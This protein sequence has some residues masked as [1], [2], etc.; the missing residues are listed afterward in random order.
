MVNGDMEEIQDHNSS[1]GH[2]TIEGDVVRTAVNTQEDDNGG[3]G[4]A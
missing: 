4:D 2:G 1:E 3:G